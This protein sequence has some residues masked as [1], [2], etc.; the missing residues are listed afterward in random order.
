MNITP[1][2]VTK[3]SL[4]LKGQMAI[5][6][7]NWHNEICPMYGITTRD[8]FHEFFANE[9]HESAC[10]TRLS[11]GL[12]YQVEALKRL[13]PKRITPDE[14][15]K[16]G[17]RRLPNGT[18]K[19]EEIKGFA[20]EELSILKSELLEAAVIGASETEAAINTVIGKFEELVKGLLPNQK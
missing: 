4:V 15:F 6:I 19:P 20:E 3:T 5:D 17:R 11:E 10:F 18:I 8:V 1:D 7:A 12:N 2:I 14:A 13:F 9:L 16:Y